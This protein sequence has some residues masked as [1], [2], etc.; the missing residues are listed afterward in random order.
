MYHQFNIQQ[1]YVLPTQ[2][3][4]VFCVDLRTNSHYFPIQNKLTGFYN[5]DAVCLLRGTNWAFICNSDQ[6]YPSNSSLYNKTARK[7]CDSRADKIER[8]SSV[9]RSTWITS[10]LTHYRYVTR[11]KADTTKAWRL[12]DDKKR[13]P[14]VGIGKGNGGGWVWGGC[15]NSSEFS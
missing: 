11:F 8:H 1:F 12:W 10:A 4:Y 5:P 2:C 9:I 15:E 13:S 14:H 3:V 7:L 6:F